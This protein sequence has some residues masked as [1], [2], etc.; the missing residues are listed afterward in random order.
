[1]LSRYNRERV[2]NFC[3]SYILWIKRPVTAR[4]LSLAFE[5]TYK[6]PPVTPGRIGNL[7]AKDERF[8]KIKGNNINFWT[9]KGV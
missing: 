8:Q 6:Y 1:M 7:L 9:I 2:L 4:E 5:S 3:Y